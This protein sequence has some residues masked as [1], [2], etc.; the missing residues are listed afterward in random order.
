MC[1]V[2]GMRFMYSSHR[3]KWFYY[4]V[5]CTSCSAAA[6]FTCIPRDA[7]QCKQDDAVLPPNPCVNICLFSEKTEVAFY[8]KKKFNATLNMN[9]VYANVK[10]PT[11]SRSN[12]QQSHLI[13]YE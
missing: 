2:F 6:W 3:H 10:S 13:N 8:G 1:F 4:Y 9:T 11:K 12:L 7:L 5:C